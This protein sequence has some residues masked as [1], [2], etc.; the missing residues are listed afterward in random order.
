MTS[1]LSVYLEGGPFFD[2][3]P[4][5]ADYPAKHLSNP[6]GLNVIQIDGHSFL[7]IEEDLNGTSK[8][9]VPA[10]V[11][12][13]TCELFLLDLSIQNPTVN[14]LIRLTVVPAG[15]EVTGI[16]QTPDKKSLLINSQHP[17]TTN[18]FPYNHSLTF[19]IHG[20]DQVSYSDLSNRSSK[21]DPEMAANDKNAAFSVFPNPTTRTVFMN[22]TTDVALYDA[23]GKRV[24]VAR[25]TN[26]VDVSTLPV[27][28]YFLKNAEGET[29]KLSVQ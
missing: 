28:V 11:S 2:N 27:G 15:A 18:P 14:D 7:A 25:N 22:K 3:S 13:R 24:L 23:N 16:V 9:R 6:D 19:A 26:E 1:E 29:L 8:G 10:G 5:E 12:N 20:L 17:S 21:V 4:A